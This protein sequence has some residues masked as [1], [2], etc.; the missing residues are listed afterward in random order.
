MTEVRETLWSWFTFSKIHPDLLSGLKK[1]GLFGLTIP[2]EVI[3]VMILHQSNPI[4]SITEL[5]CCTVRLPGDLTILSE[6]FQVDCRYYEELGA[7]LSL[8]NVISTN[9]LL[10]YRALL[11]SGSDQLKEKYLPRLATGEISAAWCLG[12]LISRSIKYIHSSSN[13][14]FILSMKF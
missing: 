4:Y 12:M 14:K 3:I 2:T 13:N 7:D 5:E 8:S 9:E 11:K 6:L 10:G 1:S